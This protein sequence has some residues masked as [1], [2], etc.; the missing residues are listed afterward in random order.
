[1]IKAKKMLSINKNNDNVK[2]ME[3]LSINIHNNTNENVLTTNCSVNTSIKDLNAPLSLIGS[4]YKNL[5]NP[6][7]VHLPKSYAINLKKNV[8]TSKICRICYCEEEE[9]NPLLQPCICSGSMKYIHLNC[10]KHWLKTS[11][12]IPIKNNKKC[13]IYNYKQAEC[14]L[15]KSKLPDFIRHQGKLYE[16]IEYTKEFK[17]YIVFETLTL[18][19]HNNKFLYVVSFDNEN[20]VISVGRS[21]ES[22]MEINEV[23]VSRAHCIIKCENK[24]IFI[25][26]KN[27]KFGTLVLIQCPRLRLSEG[28]RVFIQIGRTYL[29]SIIKPQTGFF[30]CCHVSEKINYDF[31]FQQNKSITNDFIDQIVIKTEE[32]EDDN[33]EYIINGVEDNNNNNNNYNNNEGK[34]DFITVENGKENAINSIE[35]VCSP[36]PKLKIINECEEE[37]AGENKVDE[38]K[39]RPLYENINYDTNNEENIEVIREM[40]NEQGNENLNEVQ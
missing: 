1:M 29:S 13:E 24:K 22:D 21:R 2:N 23:S 20:N 6:N 37:N 12:F 34:S 8:E 18:D 35:C 19:K 7:Q 9:E 5:I 11:S 33:E 14:E 36:L 31:Y 17:N 3:I 38:N 26:D 40:D 27:S 16:I 15:C 28:T 39:R 10:L 30:D 4:P 25:K 32:E